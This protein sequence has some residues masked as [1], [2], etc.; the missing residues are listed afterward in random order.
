MEQQKSTLQVRSIEDRDIPR[1]I[2]LAREGFDQLRPY[3]DSVLQRLFTYKWNGSDQKP[4]LGFALWAGEEIVGMLGAVYAERML[5]GRRIKT[6]N[7]STWYVRPEFRAAGIKLLSAVLLQKEYSITNFTASPSVRRIMEALGFDVI[8]NRKWVYLP[9]QCA[10]AMLRLER[11]V[12]S[13]PSEIQNIL[14]GEERQFLDEHIS[15]HV[16]HYAL[17]AEGAYSYLVL[18]R[19]R[20]PGHIVFPWVPIRKLKLIWYPCMEML[21]LG[22]PDLAIKSWDILTASIIRRERVL[23][24]VVAERFLGPTPPKGVELEHRSYLL[25]RVP[26]HTTIDS[27][28]SELAI[29]P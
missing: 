25:P 19:R 1:V 9:W 15:C 10:K 24:V 17:C 6:C 22:N 28:Y 13:S 16:S 20:I 12:I 4:N 18:K 8:D 23:A 11:Q 29:L 3:P 2:E 7:L 21:Y 27:L 5:G 26:L 14:E